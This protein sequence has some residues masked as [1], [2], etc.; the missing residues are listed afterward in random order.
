LYG[1]ASIVWFAIVSTENLSSSYP[2]LVSLTFICVT[3]GAVLFFHEL[4]SVQKI[5]GLAAIL[6]GIFLVAR[7]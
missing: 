5:A 1:A 4:V 7:G 2:L 6:L 3:S